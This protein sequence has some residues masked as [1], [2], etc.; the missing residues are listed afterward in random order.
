MPAP[1][2]PN[3]MHGL[4]H[5][6]KHAPWM[7]N[8]FPKKQALAVLFGVIVLTSMMYSSDMTNK[9][10]AQ[11]ILLAE[12]SIQEAAR[13]MYSDPKKTAV[14]VGIFSAAGSF[15]YSHRRDYIRD[16]ILDNR[17]EPRLCS[18]K[19]FIRQTEES[20]HKRVCQ[21]AYTF[22]IGAGGHDRP[23]D[24]DDNEPLTVDNDQFGNS[25]DDCTYLNVM[26]NMEDGKSPTYLKFGANIAN[27]YGIDYI[28]KTDD[29]SVISF[30]AVFDWIDSELPPSPYNRRIY[31][32]A[33]RLSRV[34]NT[35]YSAGEFY[36][37]S[38]D[39]A[40]YVGNV[41]TAGDRLSL[42]NSRPIED[43]DMGTFVFSNPRPI[44]FVSMDQK[45]IWSHPKKT[46]DEYR[47]EWDATTK[48][49]WIPRKQV[50][51]W[52]FYCKHILNGG[53]F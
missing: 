48:S 14:L 10:S 4:K 9:R 31:G 1:I 3:T 21:V 11:R 23:T 22:V 6:N 27:Q 24:H 40:D 29:D 43:L 53:C 51:Q 52:N 35:I 46:E 15:K 18:L 50:F 7:N 45:K 5:T 30:N 41:L 25:E 19:E 44:K 17:L 32:G 2:L 33:P 49:G 8:S 34:K 13:M 38:A 39:L 37:M 36:F 12:D 16:T 28:L 26:E 42:M 20:P 47:T